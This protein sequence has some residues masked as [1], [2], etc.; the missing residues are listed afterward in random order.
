MSSSPT[1]E[2]PAAE[3]ADFPQ[4]DATLPIEPL[5]P[6][7]PNERL[8]APDVLRGIGLLGI[9]L[10]N[11]IAFHTPLM[12]RQ[13]LR[14][15][16]HDRLDQWMVWLL[17]IF[18][19]GKFLTIFSL[20]FGAGFA[21]QLARVERRQGRFVALHL[22]RCLVL[23]LFGAAHIGL[24]WF[25]DILLDYAILAPILLLFRRCRPRTVIIWA[26]LFFLVP[27][28]YT[29]PRAIKWERIYRATPEDR[30]WYEDLRGQLADYRAGDQS[31]MPE[32]EAE[33]IAQVAA[34]EEKYRSTSYGTVFRERWEDIR[35]VYW[36]PPV[37]LGRTLAVLLLGLAAVRAGVLE[38]PQDHQRLLRRL[39]GPGLLLG[40]ITSV[41][42]TYYR[43]QPFAY[44]GGLS[45]FA[46]PALRS[47]AALLTALGYVAI[48]LLHLPQHGTPR[49]L[50]PLAAAGRMPLTNYL[51]QSLICTTIF[52]GYG[53]GWYGRTG[54]IVGTLLALAIFVTQAALSVVWLCYFRFGPLEWLWRSITYARLQPL[55]K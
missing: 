34:T 30:A 8:S 41:A 24:L 29:V 55:K 27:I 6:I 25:G 32:W 52:Y 9:L 1:N 40:L 20:L 11:M 5:A 44:L 21:L 19:S 53:L 43:E 38:R 4:P 50:A 10:M 17:S 23:G 26:A 48:V 37:W 18:V 13:L 22:R 54:V 46:I 3:Q 31:S 28:A 14:P 15:P 42:Y 47:V 12:A 49:G 39:A 35:R 33:Y 2:G 16:W 45:D 7:T 51:S 36:G